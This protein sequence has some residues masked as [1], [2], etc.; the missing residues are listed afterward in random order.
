MKQPELFGQIASNL[1]V[2][3][4]NSDNSFGKESAAM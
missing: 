3:E 4:N 2:L 1:A